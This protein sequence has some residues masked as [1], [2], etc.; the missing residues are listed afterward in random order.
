MEEIPTQTGMVGPFWVVEENR[1]PVVI[2]LTVP[3][4]LADP[5][6]VNRRTTGTPAEQP[7]KS[8]KH[9][10]NLPFKW[11]PDR[12]RSGPHPEQRFLFFIRELAGL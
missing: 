11:G 4:A 7:A 10:C 8:F 6:G 2:A 1:K 9:K 12:R 5:Y 3:L